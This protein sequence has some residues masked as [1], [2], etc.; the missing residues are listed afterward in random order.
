MLLGWKP[1]WPHKKHVFR[2]SRI[3]DQI[4]MPLGASACKAHPGC[5]FFMLANIWFAWQYPVN[6]TYDAVH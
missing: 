1:N 3:L 4:F 2:L 6:F 5:A